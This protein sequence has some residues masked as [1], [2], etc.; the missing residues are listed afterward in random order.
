MLTVYYKGIL[1]VNTKINKIQ[2]INFNLK[3]SKLWALFVQQ[4]KL[5]KISVL[6]KIQGREITYKKSECPITPM[7][8]IIDAKEK[9][10]IH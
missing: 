3:L 2:S 5:K 9:Q 1:S 8:L 10:N 6:Y 4:E 7:E